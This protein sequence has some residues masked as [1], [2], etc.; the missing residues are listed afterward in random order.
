MEFFVPNY[1]TKK[2][3]G[4]II[5]DAGHWYIHKSKQ[6][7]ISLIATIL[8]VLSI[9]VMIV[10]NIYS[11][12]WFGEG[13]LIWRVF[14]VFVM[15]MMCI[16]IAS[17]GLG[18]VYA[19]SQKSVIIAYLN[20]QIQQ[21]DNARKILISEEIKDFRDN[22]NSINL[23]LKKKMIVT[24]FQNL[25]LEEQNKLQDKFLDVLNQKQINLSDLPTELLPLAPTKRAAHLEM[26]TKRI[27][28]FHYL[29]LAI[30]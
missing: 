16:G 15:L 18:I 26:L 9:G 22:W 14:K 8:T 6:L 3:P 12:Q 17:I 7:S 19:M 24:E 10:G 27:V 29:L 20:Y 30:S 11:E 23:I 2:V 5:H 13:S 28:Y 21:C 25:N 4:K 1:D